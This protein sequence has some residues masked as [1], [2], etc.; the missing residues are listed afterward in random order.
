MPHK[1]IHIY[2]H[3]G[4]EV[5][6]ILGDGQFETLDTSKIV[7]G[8]TLNNVTKNEH[9]PVVEYYVRTIKERICSVYDSLPFKR[10]QTRLIGKIV[11]A[12]VFWLNSFP[13]D[14]GI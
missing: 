12:Q 9:V 10:F 14:N 8:V 6:H 7:V 1:I 3:Y 13:S 4:F 11:H 5:T 2:T